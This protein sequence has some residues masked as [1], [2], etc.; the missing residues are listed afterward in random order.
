VAPSSPQL[1]SLRAK[2]KERFHRLGGGVRE[3]LWMRGEEGRVGGRLPGAEDPEVARA[4]PGPPT[5]K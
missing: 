1:S 5:K 4:S 3:L 2:S